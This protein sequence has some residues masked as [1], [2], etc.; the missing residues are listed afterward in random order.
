M[1]H[2]HVHKNYGQE[3]VRERIHESGTKI[4]NAYGSQVLEIEK[5]S[6]PEQGKTGSFLYDLYTQMANARKYR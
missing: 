6:Y 3:F 5:G 2:G 1:A 4:I